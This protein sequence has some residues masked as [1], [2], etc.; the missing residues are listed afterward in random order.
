MSYSASRAEGI[1][2]SPIAAR[3]SGAIGRGLLE[4]TLVVFVTFTH[5]SLSNPYARMLAGVS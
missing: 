5:T 1:S 3:V 2:F 4:G